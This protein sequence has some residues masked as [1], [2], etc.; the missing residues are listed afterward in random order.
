[1]G[2]NI[3]LTRNQPTEVFEANITHNL[4][5]MADAVGIYGPLWRPEDSGIKTAGDLIPFLSDG[6][7]EL[8][9]DPER[10]RKLE[11][12]N[13][14]GTYDDFVPWL[15]RYLAACIEYPDAEISASR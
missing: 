8:K 2:L 1:M 3:T 14:W 6:I 4:N 13:G 15:K 12:E 10:Y 7:A 5:K 11:P 9:R